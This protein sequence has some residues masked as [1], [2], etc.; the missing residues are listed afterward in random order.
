MGEGSSPVKF[1]IL[2]GL[3]NIFFFFIVCDLLLASNFLSF[4][5]QNIKILIDR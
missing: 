4:Q 3:T 1:V 2:I 5:L